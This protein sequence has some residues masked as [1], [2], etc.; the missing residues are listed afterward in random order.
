VTGPIDKDGHVNYATA[1]NQL[2]QE[3]VTAENNA[4]VLLV[5]AFGPRPSGKAIQPEYFDWMGIAAPA[6]DGEYFAPFESFRERKLKATSQERITEL[7]ELLTRSQGAPWSANER[8][9]IARWLKAN[10]KPLALVLEA[11]MRPRYFSPCVPKPARDG[12]TDLMTGIALS[13]QGTRD[14]AKALAAQAMLKT[15]E[16]DLDA[17]WKHALACHRL[18]CHVGSGPVLIDGL[19]GLAIE[20]I[21]NRAVLGLLGSGKLSA[22]QI[23]ACSRDLDALPKLPDIAEKMQVGE[24][25][26]FLSSLMLLDAYGIRYLRALADAETDETEAAFANLILDDVNWDPVL[27]EANRRHDRIAAALRIPEHTKRQEEFKR[28]DLELAA[29][30]KKAIDREGFKKAMKEGANAAAV[31]GEQIGAILISLVLPSFEKTQG[32][33]DRCQQTR[34]NTRIAFSLEAYKKDHGRYPKK[35]QDLIPKHLQQL[36]QDRYSGKPVIYRPVADGYTLYSVGP[37]GKDD[38]GRGL[39]D[40]PAGDDL[41]V[42]MPF[43][44]ATNK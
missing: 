34:E 35:L 42:R 28:I 12:K 32:A 38:D 15:E 9:E 30:K 2:L 5:R 4:N 11:T 1:L 31:L 19:V 25:F 43:G 44:A 39:N 3:G 13:V 20:G 26:V 14:A 23:L 18:G 16:G 41:A 7:D 21:A 6:E 40:K 24:R 36:P 22:E 8:P 27:I 10:E 29:L 17:A 37:D 33:V